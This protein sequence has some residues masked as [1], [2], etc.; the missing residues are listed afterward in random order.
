VSDPR[1]A[2]CVFCDLVAGR[3]ERSVAFEDDLCVVL[4]DSHPIT[5]GHSLV[6]PKRHASRL[7]ELDDRAWGHLCLVAKRLE[8]TIREVGLRCEG[9]NLLVA[10]GEAAFQAVPHVHVHVLPRYRGDS[11]KIQADWSSR[12]S[13]QELDGVAARLRASYAERWGG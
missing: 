10:D 12:P 6:I 8:A 13:R 1:P 9:I 4:V 5:E 2:S 11:F 7:H 3:A